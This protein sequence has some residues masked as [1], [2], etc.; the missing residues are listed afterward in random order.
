MV[1]DSRSLYNLSFPSVFPLCPPSL[2]LVLPLLVSL[3]GSLDLSWA[4]LGSFG[5]FWGSLGPVLGLSAALLVSLG[6]LLSSPGALL[7]PFT[8]SLAF[9]GRS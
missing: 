7:A 9:V 3:W 1:P 4:P 6:P 5:A 8:L 2:S